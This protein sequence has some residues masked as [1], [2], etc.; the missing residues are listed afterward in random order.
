MES[1]RSYHQELDD[2]RADMVKLAATVVEN[3]P[4]GT[5]VLLDGDL[6]A[7]DYL[8]LSD[9]EMN[10]RSV[11]L[12]ERCYEVIALQQPMAGD[13]RRLM[14]AVRMIGEIER[15]NDLVVNICKA[16]RRLY[17]HPLDPKL[18][19]MVAKMSDLAHQL[20]RFAVDAYDEA[21]GGLAAALD[22][23]DDNL[24]TVHGEFIA[25]IFDCHKA[26]S[27]ELEQAV[28]L[29]LVARFYERIGDHA[30]NIGERVHYMVTGLLEDRE[31][32]DRQR[33]AEIEPPPGA[34]N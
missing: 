4:R 9:D 26:G 28:Q 27:L 20:F 25:A 17:G 31:S 10:D 33:Q 21:D 3:I 2:I 12:E 32:E 22:D 1:R 7:A 18:R 14:A 30:V 8:I 11:A 5:Q 34:G 16:A 29:A 23:M 19:G 6:E 13:L 24:D 15:S